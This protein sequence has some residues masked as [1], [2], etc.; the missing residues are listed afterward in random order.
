MKKSMQK[1]I[2]FWRVF[3]ACFIT[4]S[5][6]TFL[7]RVPQ[8]QRQSTRM[9]K[10]KREQSCERT[11]R[12]AVVIHTL[13]TACV[14]RTLMLFQKHDI[15]IIRRVTQTLL[16]AFLR[17]LQN[18]SPTP[19]L[20]LYVVWMLYHLYVHK[21]TYGSLCNQN[22]VLTGWQGNYPQNTVFSPQ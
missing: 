17:E 19:K 7:C 5:L 20:A 9:K 8:P 2:N 11:G 3:P 16:Q 21:F 14:T 18:C 12:C 22:A 13:R 1:D 4:D 15:A 10:I 6:I